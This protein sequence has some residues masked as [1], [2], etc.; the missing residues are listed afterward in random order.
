MNR[1]IYAWFAAFA[2]LLVPTC[3]QQASP[4]TGAAGMAA[5]ASPTQGP[6]LKMRPAPKPDEGS[7]QLDVV[8][9]DKQGIPVTGLDLND[10]TLL[11]DKK[12]AKIVSFRANNALSQRADDSTQVILL[13]DAVNLDYLT[14]SRTRDEIAKFLRQ[15][16]G[17]LAQPVSIMLLSN[18]GA[19]V[20]LQPS[21]NGNAL[22]AE[23]D[24]TN[25]ALRVIDRAGGVN[26]DS[27][28]V[29]LSIKWLTIIAETEAKLPGR[30]L[31][32]WTG[33]GWPMLDRATVTPSLESVRLLFD[34]AV[35]ISTTL[36]NAR[37]TLYDV[38]LPGHDPNLDANL[39]DANL[40]ESFL[41]GVR[42]AD[43]IQSANLDLKVIAI[44]SG[45]RVMFP[46]NDLATQIKRCVQDA[47]AFYT[48][49]FNPPHA[50]RPDEYH[51]L[52]VVID[53]RKIA[54]RTNTGYYNQP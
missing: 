14:L 48:L 7:I 22:A 44:Q 35:D 28:R 15:N 54:A 36:R 16:G 11:D 4:A 40:Y 1:Q 51:E 25:A 26:G 39:L 53:K 38:A 52:K 21:T 47:G 9:T 45:G 3:A 41:K 32:I 31:L 17:H 8:V 5:Q 29:G 12:P 19:T 50:D 43:Q 33:P 2:L 34:W 18:D 20:L 46:D 6:A 23:L 13:L 42:N 10:F 37:M 27:E 30:K 24:K 49:S